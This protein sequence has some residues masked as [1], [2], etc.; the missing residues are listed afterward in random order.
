NFKVLQP[1]HRLNS[2]A[3]KRVD[4]ASGYLLFE[5][6]ILDSCTDQYATVAARHQ[7][8]L[9]R[10]NYT[11]DWHLRAAHC[12]H[13][14]VCR[15]GFDVQTDR[16]KQTARPGSCCDDDTTGVEP[17][18]ADRDAGDPVVFNRDA[19][20]RSAFPYLDAGSPGRNIEGIHQP[21]ILDL[22]I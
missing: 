20:D 18:G 22:V 13:L 3:Q 4:G 15:D 9:V 16:S 8:T 19:I 11:G 5:T 2:R 12:H 14:P 7:I 6:D 17:I 21:A 1:R 10:V